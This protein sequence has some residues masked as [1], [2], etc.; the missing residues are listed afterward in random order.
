MEYSVEEV[1]AMMKKC[2]SELSVHMSTDDIVNI[3]NS[4]AFDLAEYDDYAGPASSLLDSDGH[5][6]A[7]SDA[8]FDQMESIISGDEPGAF[9]RIKDISSVVR[10]AAIDALALDYALSAIDLLNDEGDEEAM[11]GAVSSFTDVFET[12][13]GL[14]SIAGTSFYGDMEKLIEI[15]NAGWEIDMMGFV[16]DE[17]PESLDRGEPKEY[18]RG[19]EDDGSSI[20]TATAI[21]SRLS[22]ITDDQKSE[23]MSLVGKR[24]SNGMLEY[25]TTRLVNM[26]N[27]MMQENISKGDDE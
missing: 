6:S 2:V 22:G 19:A 20:E 7:V 16:D 14:A 17:P 24:D 15:A 8:A 10:Q 23:L 25:D 5:P 18:V 4:I 1:K 13:F 3:G 21:I 9:G 27:K 26:A 11:L 12:T